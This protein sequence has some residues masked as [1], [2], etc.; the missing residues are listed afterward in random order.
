M[1]IEAR[2]LRHKESLRQ[3]ILD[4]ARD[5]FVNE[6]YKNASIRKIAEKIEYSP[7]TIYSY[8]S[9]KSELLDALLEETFTGLD[10][11]LRTISEQEPDSL[12][13]LR[14]GLR[15]YIEFGLSN[16]NHYLLVFVLDENSFDSERQQFKGKYGFQCFGNLRR[17]VALAMQD[18]H[19][20]EA[21]LET[22]S[23]ALWAAMHGMT[24]LL[25]SQPGFPFVERE[26]LIDRLLDILLDGSRKRAASRQ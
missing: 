2:K 10:A 9:D 13:A 17:A 5:L 4:A 21:D 18:G 22:T 25:I 1:G 15:A 16:P 24:S 7:A 19:L 23:Q 26:V 11:E 6:G 12:V 3:M 20:A 8:F 14:Q